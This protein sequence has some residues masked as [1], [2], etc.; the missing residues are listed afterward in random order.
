MS[1]WFSAFYLIWAKVGDS[2]LTVNEGLNVSSPLRGTRDYRVQH[3]YCT[4]HVIVIRTRKV[5]PGWFSD[6]LLMPRFFIAVG[7]SVTTVFHGSE[8]F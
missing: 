6:C 7:S 3:M 4:G 5:G 2:F 8:G 1:N